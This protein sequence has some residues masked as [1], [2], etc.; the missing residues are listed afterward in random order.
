MFKIYYSES[1]Q[2]TNLLWFLE[3]VFDLEEF[4]CKNLIQLDKKKAQNY[5]FEPLMYFMKFVF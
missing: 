5:C 1:C 3:L 4:N 2:V